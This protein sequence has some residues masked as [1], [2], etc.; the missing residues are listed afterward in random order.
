M[1]E[2]LPLDSKTSA[3]N[4]IVNGKS[5]GIIGRKAF[6]AR[7]PKII[8]VNLKTKQRKSYILNSIV[9]SIQGALFLFNTYVSLCTKDTSCMAAKW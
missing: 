2:P 1:F 7:A 8:K 4:L 9:L 6:S 3:F 5:F